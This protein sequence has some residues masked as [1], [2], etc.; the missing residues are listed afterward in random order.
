MG[1]SLDAAAMR[2]IDAHPAAP[3]YRP[4]RAA[5]HGSSATAGGAIRG[6][7]AEDAAPELPQGLCPLVPRQGRAFGTLYLAG[8]REGERRERESPCRRCRS[9]PSFPPSS[10]QSNRWIAKA[11][12]MLGSRRQ[13]PL[14]EPLTRPPGAD[15]ALVWRHVAGY[16][17]H[18]L[19]QRADRLVLPAGG[20]AGLGQDQ[21]GRSGARCGFASGR[22]PRA[23]PRPCRR[24]ACASA[25]WR[26]RRRLP[27]T[28]TRA[29]SATSCST[30]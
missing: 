9:G 13:S 11:P 19:R 14:A 10:I 15:S 24:A 2:E 7:K 23:V 27:K 29:P 21:R 5:V 12:P 30:C 16:E 26:T 28:P 25:G 1:W 18:R 4:G 17:R 3:R 8:W 6:V 20:G 22:G